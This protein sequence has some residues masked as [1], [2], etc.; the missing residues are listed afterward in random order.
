M[1][2]EAVAVEAAV[3]S[4]K[5]PVTPATLAEKAPRKGLLRGSR[6]STTT[7]RGTGP[8]ESVSVVAGRKVVVVEPVVVGGAKTA[9]TG[10]VPK[11]TVP[12][13]SVKPV[14][15]TAKPGLLPAKPSAAATKTTVPVS[16]SLAKPTR[17][18]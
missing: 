17:V 15:T 14:T 9:V 5:T 7:A 12:V 3:V 1:A 4:A 10:K 18:K 2:V 6:P 16:G 11:V 13:K 8:A